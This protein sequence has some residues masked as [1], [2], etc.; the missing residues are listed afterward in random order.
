[1]SSTTLGN[2]GLDH[3]FFN[4]RAP[5]RFAAAFDGRSSRFRVY[6]N[7]PSY[8]VHAA[9]EENL[10]GTTLGPR[11]YSFDSRES[12]SRRGIVLVGERRSP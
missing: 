3:E 1:M 5:L 2:L 12:S 7:A 9:F 4:S 10:C 8:T 11:T 6:D